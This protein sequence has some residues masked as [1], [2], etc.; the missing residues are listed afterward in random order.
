MSRIVS[1]RADRVT[2]RFRRPFP[3]A[4]GMWNAREAWILRVTDAEGR[5][6]V[7]EA[8][9]EP[10]D[11]EVAASVLESLVREAVAAGE[12]GRLPTG[13]ELE[14]HGRPGRALRAALDAARFDLEREPSADV[15]PDGDGVGVN[16]TLPLLGPRPSAEA[17]LQAVEAGFRTLKV[18]G[19][20]ERET[21]A[22]VD[23]IRAVRQ[24]VGPDVRL[25]LDVNGSW[26]PPTAEERL[27]AVARF[28]LE[29][30][31]QPLAGDDAAALAALRRRV[32]VPIAADESV[33]S[34]KAAGE[35]LEAE[36]V[37]VL[38]VKPARVGGI[39]A[40]REIAAMAADR[41]VPVVVSTLF[42]TGVG[43]A[44][45]LALAAALPRVG[46]GLD[47]GLATAG[48]LEHDLLRDELDVE[49]GRMW[50]PDD[51][52]PG[53]LGIRIDDEAVERYRAEAVE[54]VE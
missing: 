35:L 30:V 8:V 29:Y 24:A 23:R 40:G 48:L 53:G 37:D 31:E 36:A 38:V 22:L 6:G 14:G 16:A 7:G 10:D 49:D 11:G 3:V 42:E 17:A 9:V 27:E 1:V 33:A 15:L 13:D 19:G 2:V 26:D 12:A 46:D 4:A 54:A 21:E 52:G 41:G 20:A 28:D 47:H 18:K 32:R 39:E 34:A 45:A 25:R 5:V 50:L 51:P 43:I 44:A